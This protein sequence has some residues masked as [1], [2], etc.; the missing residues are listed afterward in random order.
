MEVYRISLHFIIFPN[1]NKSRAVDE[2]IE[3]P[4]L[5]YVAGPG[6]SSVGFGAFMEH[7]PLKPADDGSGRSSGAITRGTRVKC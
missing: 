4:C 6:C 1:G 7:G 3:L 5:M 2:T